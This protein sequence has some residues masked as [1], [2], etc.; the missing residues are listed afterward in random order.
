MNVFFA[1]SA[2]FELIFAFFY[3]NAL[4]L[5]ARI[6]ADMKLRPS[7]IVVSLMNFTKG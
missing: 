5:H 2:D 6:R 4:Y 1:N 3:K 7:V